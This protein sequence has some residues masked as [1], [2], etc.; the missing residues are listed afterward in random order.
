MGSAYTPGLKVSPH[1]TIRRTRRLPLKGEVL[2]SAGQ[3]VT[4]DTVVARAALPGL[5][6]TVKVAGLLGIDA[7]ELPAVLLVKEGEAV[8][9]GQ[10]LAQTKSFF[11]MF[12]SE[13]KSPL[14]GVVE[15]ISGVSGNVGIRRAPT[16]IELTAYLAGTVA[17]VLPGEGVIVQA[18]GALTQGIFGIGGERVGEILVASPSPES[19][20][21]EA[22]LTPQMAGRIILG[23]ANISGAALRRAAE[24]GVTGIVVGGIID[25]DLI[26]YLGYDIG[27]A[28]TGHENIPLTLVITEGFGT[29]AMAH[30][31]YELLASLA[32]RTASINGATQIRA[33][34]IRPEIIVPD[35]AA[36]ANPGRIREAEGDGA[37]GVGTPIRIIREPYFGALATVAAL[38]PQL[39]TVASGAS[40]RVLD[41][42]LADGQTVTVP[43]A[44]VEI[45][46]TS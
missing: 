8:T 46:E 12:K 25:K 20:L 32:G 15:T 42:R 23:G 17:E 2:V 44:N 28:I 26:E 24:L 27:V 31:T 40:V 18:Q 9:Q 4:P 34:V 21:T 6:Q 37:L 33:G 1:T 3:T 38:P 19:D 36:T 7:D 43:R 30:R 11:G 45:M 29:I 39:V 5:M 41:A 13:A 35:T 22:D 14:D 10:V 16:P